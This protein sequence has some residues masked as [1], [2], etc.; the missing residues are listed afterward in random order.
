MILETRLNFLL[1]QAKKVGWHRKRSAAEKLYRNILVEAPDSV[2]AHFGLAETT[3]D[4]DERTQLYTQILELEPDNEQAQAALRGE[5]IESLFVIVPELEEEDEDE[6]QT[7]AQEQGDGGR[8]ENVRTMSAGVDT[9]LE[10]GDKKEKKE[11]KKKK[12]A[13]SKKKVTASDDKDKD[14]EA[15]DIEHCHRHHDTPTSLRCYDCDKLICIK[16]A[17]K[18]PVGYI[19]PDCKR[20]LEDTYFTAKPTDYLI[21][22]AVSLP[23]SIAIGALVVMG[24]S[25]LGFWALFIM[26]AVGGF[27]GNLIGRAVKV[28]IGKRRGRYIP[29]LVAATVGLGVSWGFLLMFGNILGMIVLG[30]YIFVAGGAAFYWSK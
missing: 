12:T 6:E 10:T 21:A 2:E 20:D 5:V 4:L 27:I 28:A 30:L 8:A 13:V 17:N 15:G 18:T 9:K 24:S 11:E 25:A 29:H 1:R 7:E 14:G 26:S 3:L 23:L 16:C 19:C 22:L